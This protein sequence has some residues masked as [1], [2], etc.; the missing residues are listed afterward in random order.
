MN[1]LLLFASCAM[2]IRPQAWPH[3]H[4]RT[5]PSTLRVALRGEV[6]VA[7]NYRTEGAISQQA[8]VNSPGEPSWRVNSGTSAE[9][10]RASR[11]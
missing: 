7:H 1:S 2:L 8:G 11:G 6:R 10:L 3:R 5:C 9:H 4:T